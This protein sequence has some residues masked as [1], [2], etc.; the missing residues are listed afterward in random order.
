MPPSCCA[1]AEHLPVA[2]TCYECRRDFCNLCAFTVRVR[3]DWCQGQALQTL[4]SQG[5]GFDAGLAAWQAREGSVPLVC[6][7]CACCPPP[8]PT[9]RD[10]LL[11]VLAE[12][13]ETR[14][15]AAVCESESALFARIAADAF[16]EPLTL[17]ELAQIAR[18]LL[19]HQAGVRLATAVGAEMARLQFA[20]LAKLH[21]RMQ[22]R[23]H[24][25][26]SWLDTAAQGNEE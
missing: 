9:L 20:R 4:A 12:M 18:G 19:A 17:A 2:V 1:G 11:A 8:A 7:D 14:P 5:K 22:R 6:C 24:G 26:E 13:P 23:L 15:L 21:A 3:A 16:S 25:V 10:L